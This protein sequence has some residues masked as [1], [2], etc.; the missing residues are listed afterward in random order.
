MPSGSAD[1]WCI[2]VTPIAVLAIDGGLGLR[3]LYYQEH[4][5][6]PELILLLVLCGISRQ[7]VGN[8]HYTA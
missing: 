2:V 1:L 4:N 3:I 6:L 7:W 5:K 8:L